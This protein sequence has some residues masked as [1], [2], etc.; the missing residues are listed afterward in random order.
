MHT[1]QD[2]DDAREYDTRIQRNRNPIA[3]KVILTQYKRRR[4]SAQ[5]STRTKYAFGVGKRNGTKN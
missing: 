1:P 2:I 3:S 4:R 5:C